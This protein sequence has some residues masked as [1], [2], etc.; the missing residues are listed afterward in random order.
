MKR[1]AKTAVRQGQ[2][3]LGSFLKNRKR[4]APARKPS[5][6]NQ[7]SS[8]DNKKMQSE[9]LNHEPDAILISPQRDK[10]V[11]TKTGELEELPPPAPHATIEEEEHQEASQNP[12]SEDTAHDTATI[13][14]ESKAP[15]TPPSILKTSYAQAAAA[16][17]HLPNPP[18]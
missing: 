5:P 4:S 3:T 2:G 10:N 11:S 14:E 7:T 1:T 6:T 15:S 8:P 12:Q 17:A 13:D 18:P 9:E 16:A